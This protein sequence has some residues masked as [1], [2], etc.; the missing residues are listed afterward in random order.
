MRDC[1]SRDPS[2]IL[3]HCIILFVFYIDRPQLTGPRPGTTVVG[4]RHIYVHY[5]SAQNLVQDAALIR[6][7]LAFRSPGAFF[8]NASK[9]R[10]G[11]A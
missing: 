1:H 4:T 8:R 6:R 7:S 11:V 9:T 2:S 5:R 3:G 10:G